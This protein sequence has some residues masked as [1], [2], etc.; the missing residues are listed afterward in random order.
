MMRQLAEADIEIYR[1]VITEMSEDL[2]A[3]IAIRSLD[4]QHAGLLVRIVLHR[5]QKETQSLRNRDSQYDD[6]NGLI[7]DLCGRFGWSRE[8]K[9]IGLTEFWKIRKSSLKNAF[10]RKSLHAAESRHRIEKRSAYGEAKGD[11]KIKSKVTI[12]G[13]IKDG[14]GPTSGFNLNDG[15]NGS[16]K[17]HL[18]S[19]ESHF[20]NV[21][22][23][24]KS[25]EKPTEEFKFK[26]MKKTAKKGVLM[27]KDRLNRK[28]RTIERDSFKSNARGRRDNGFARKGTCF[29]RSLSKEDYEAAVTTNRN[30]EVPPEEERSSSLFYGLKSNVQHHIELNRRFL[31]KVEHELIDS[32]CQQLVIGISETIL[33]KK[34]KIRAIHAALQRQE[35]KQSDYY[36]DI[37]KYLEI[38]EDYCD[39]VVKHKKET[40]TKTQIRSQQVVEGHADSQKEAADI[41]RLLQDLRK[42]RELKYVDLRT[43][44]DVEDPREELILKIPQY[45]TIRNRTDNK[46]HGSSQDLTSSA[47]QH[48]AIPTNR[49]S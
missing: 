38:Y 31:K 48:P 25:E 46:K 10:S 40:R 23:E 6:K 43:I 29:F 17:P 16:S 32:E 8:E 2:Q 41:D 27:R 5:I 22:K 34:R 14:A 13:S 39:L 35:V 42:E 15:R 49:P 36:N 20:S 4:P 26:E 11:K 28:D 21:S 45:T 24:D 37:L 18:A 3:G 12:R 9:P 33:T 30:I 19:S 1:K 44:F 7:G 47:H